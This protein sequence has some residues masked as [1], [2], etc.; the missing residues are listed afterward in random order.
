MSKHQSHSVSLDVVENNFDALQIID[1]PRTISHI[2]SKYL[3][4]LDV[5]GHHA[6]EHHRLL[7]VH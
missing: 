3:D 7:A 5:A 6:S 1:S 4:Q 2:F